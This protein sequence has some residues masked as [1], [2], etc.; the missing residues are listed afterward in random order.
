M[1]RWLWLGG[2]A[3]VLAVIIIASVRGG[4]SSGEKVYLEQPKRMDIQSV[5]SATG[6]IDPKLKVNISAHVIGKIEHL[7]FNEGDEVRKGD[8]LVDLEK[9]IFVAQRD[10]MRAELA[11]QH[12]GVQRAR[13]NLANAKLRLDRASKLLNQGIQAQELYDQTRLDYENARSALSSAAQGVRQAE[14]GLKEAQTDLDRTTIES[15]ITGRVVTAASIPGRWAA[16]PA[17]ATITLM[18]RSAASPP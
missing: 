18:P 13:I 5:V 4:G 12:I 6:E 15:P 9:N 16:P 7:Y 3:I 11:N 2:G 10:R 1:K 8:R 17:P 14:A